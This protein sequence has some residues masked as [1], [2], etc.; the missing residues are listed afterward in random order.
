MMMVIDLGLRLC[1]ALSVLVS[2]ISAGFERSK[3]VDFEVP[4]ATDRYVPSVR[5]TTLVILYHIHT[6]YGQTDDKKLKNTN[7]EMNNIQHTV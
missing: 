5:Y 2:D 1:C 7:R 3:K 4:R 6:W